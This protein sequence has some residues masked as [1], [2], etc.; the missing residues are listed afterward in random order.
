[1]C[2]SFCNY[3]IFPV[4][5]CF[6]FI[7][8]IPVVVFA[9]E[10]ISV[11]IEGVTTF[12]YSP[13]G[14][15]LVQPDGIIVTVSEFSGHHLGL[16][17]MENQPILSV[18]ASSSNTTLDESITIQKRLIE[19]KDNYSYDSEGETSFAGKPAFFIDFTY[20]DEFGNEKAVHEII[21]INEGYKYILMSTMD[22][23]SSN[24]EIIEQMLN[25]FEFIPISE[26]GISKMVRSKMER[27]N[28]PSKAYRH[29][30]YSLSNSSDYS[31]DYYYDWCNC[32]T[33][34][35]DYYCEC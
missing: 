1:M 11:P 19:D 7:G 2:S 20:T 29:L 3:K 26:D 17:V 31:W 4:F 22:N 28:E 32:N 25:S 35:I 12:K 5:V 9:G 21:A 27:M 18:D 33:S 23:S 13:A 8:I 24:T 14:Y 34:Y 15:S 16:F 30:S 6:I 10:E